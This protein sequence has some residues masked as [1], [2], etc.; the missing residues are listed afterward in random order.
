MRGRLPEKETSKTW[1]KWGRN[2][3]PAGESAI[4]RHGG[5]DVSST[6][7]E[8]QGACVVTGMKEGVRSWRGNQRGNKGQRGQRDL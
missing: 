6:F 4:K 3:F 2:L 5:G 7:E 1:R 8:H